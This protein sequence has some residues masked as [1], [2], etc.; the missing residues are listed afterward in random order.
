MSSP[1]LALFV[2]S[3][4]QDCY[5]KATYWTRGGLCGLTALFLFMIVAELKGVGAPGLNCFMVISV[6]QMMAISLIGLTYFGSA[7]AEEKEEETLGLLRMTDL[8]PLSILLGKSTSR[9]CGALLLLVTALPFTIV[10]VTLGGVSLHQIAATYCTIAAYTFLVC[11]VALLGS[12]LARNTAR[13]AVFTAM[14]IGVL[15]GTGPALVVLSDDWGTNRLTAVADTLSHVTPIGRLTTILTTHYSGPLATRT[16]AGCVTLGLGSFLL[17]WAAFDRFCDCGQDAPASTAGAPVRV[18]WWRIPRP[19]RPKRFAIAW[20]DYHFLFG[21]HAGLVIR[22]LVYL[23]LPAVTL[24]LLK[25]KRDSNL[26]EVLS[27]FVN[28]LAIFYYIDVGAMAARLFRHELNEQTLSSLAILPSTI[29]RVAWRKALILLLVALPG[30]VSLIGLGILQLRF[31]GG[32]SF[33][34]TAM[35]VQAGDGAVWAVLYAHWV[36][37]ASLLVKRGGLPLG[38]V[39]AAIYGMLMSLLA[40]WIAQR[41]GLAF[42][43]NSAMSYE[44]F[45]FLVTSGISLVFIVFLHIRSLRRLEALSA[46]G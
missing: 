35:I 40:S 33:S 11:N 12:V 44:T 25:L 46:E 39:A 16:E 43:G 42:R 24:G 27:Y 22:V 34:R 7:V 20:K 23:V 29:R 15:L 32:A 9:L 14:V 3:L 13:A 37:F 5:G 1:L 45:L 17:A 2:Q 38:I 8:N 6:L 26:G 31:Y 21:G 36:L 41:S 19:S 28:W 4:S 10:A 18:L 30:T